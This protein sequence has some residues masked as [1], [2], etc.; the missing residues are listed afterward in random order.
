MGDV[1]KF[2]KL[3]K[4]RQSYPHIYHLTSSLNFHQFLKGER[5][6][7][8]V[9]PEGIAT[10]STIPAPEIDR[11]PDTNINWWLLGGITLSLAISATWICFACRAFR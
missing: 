3:K 9:T 7:F 10:F 2:R 11:W 5:G 4:R 6:V 1:I 8:T